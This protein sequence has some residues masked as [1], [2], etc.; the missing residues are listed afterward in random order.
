MWFS[1][2]KKWR[3]NGEEEIC[4]KKTLAKDYLKFI[5]NIKPQIQESLK[6]KTR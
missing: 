1:S 3:D 2:K 6:P 5:K 4:G